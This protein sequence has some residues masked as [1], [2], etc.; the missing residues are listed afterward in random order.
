MHTHR[1][2]HRWGQSG[3]DGGHRILKKNNTTPRPTVRNNAQQ[4]AAA[5]SKAQQC[6]ATLDNAQQGTQTKSNTAHTEGPWALSAMGME[7]TCSLVARASL[8]FLHSP[9]GR[10]AT[11]P[12]TGYSAIKWM[13]LLNLNQGV[14]H[15]VI[16]NP[17]DAALERHLARQTDRAFNMPNVE[18]QLHRLALVIR[19]V[20]TAA[21]GGRRAQPGARELLERL[22]LVRTRR[23]AAEHV[24]RHARLPQQPQALREQLRGGAI[25]IAGELHRRRLPPPRRRRAP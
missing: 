3:V 23:A 14:T 9:L 19:A 7:G 13:A 25:A 6:R 5:H 18:P 24:H 20:G 17:K 22:E 8:T 21:A 10:P 15:L 2:I 12:Q 1:S 16:V 11:A 4:R